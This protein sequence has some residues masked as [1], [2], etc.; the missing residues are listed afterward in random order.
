MMWTTRCALACRFLFAAS[1]LACGD[2]PETIRPVAVD[3]QGLSASADRITASWVVDFECS[4]VRADNVRDLPASGQ[5][6]WTSDQ[7]E[8]RIEL[9]TIREEAALIV[10]YV[11]D[12]AARL[13]QTGCTKVVF[14]NVESPDLEPIRLMDVNE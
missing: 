6:E 12:A 4:E 2:D 11:E 5:A 14:E 7:P 3:L 9:P 8:R 10:V 13:L 1:V